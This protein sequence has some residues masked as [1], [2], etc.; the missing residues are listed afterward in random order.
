MAVQ[1]G[2]QGVVA[3]ATRLSEVDGE[4]GHLTLAGYA[5]EELAPGASF[6]EVVHLLWRGRLPSAAEHAEL[7]AELG[8]RRAVPAATL[9][10]LSAAAA[11]RLPHMDALRMGVASLGLG[12]GKASPE[13][14]ALRL[15]AAF[16]ALVGAYGGAVGAL[17]GPLHGGAP[18]PALDMVLE[19]AR[20]E[21]AEAVL[22]EKLE[23]GERLMGFGE[24]S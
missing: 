2:L 3:A 12:D 16:P 18:G 7:R 8:A 23:R 15:V 19:I 9:S 5:V 1:E 22:R 21:R 10:L 24:I 4:A 6:E 11:E 14:A 13:Q 17:K 20:P